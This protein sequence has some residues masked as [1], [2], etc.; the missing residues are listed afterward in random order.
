MAVCCAMNSI[1]CVTGV[2]PALGLAAAG[3]FAAG[4]AVLVHRFLV[5]AA[6]SCIVGRCIFLLAG[7]CEAGAA[8]GRVLP[9][10][11]CAGRTVDRLEA[12]FGR[13]RGRLSAWMSSFACIRADM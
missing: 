3:G 13:S 4:V 10:G 2:G 11:S 6:L 5:V 7:V 1:M 12:A 9:R 8:V